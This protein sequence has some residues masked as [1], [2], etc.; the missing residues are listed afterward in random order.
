MLITEMLAHLSDLSDDDLDALADAV[1][2]EIEDRE[3]GDDTP[4][5][6]LLD[7]GDDE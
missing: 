5:D 4:E 7:D 6:D 3:E 2:A 1:E